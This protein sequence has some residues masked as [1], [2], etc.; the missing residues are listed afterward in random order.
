MGGSV[1][2][3]V[4]IAGVSR[5]SKLSLSVTWEVS[6]DPFQTDNISTFEVEKR[7]RHWAGMDARYKFNPHHSLALFAG[8]R[9]GGPACT[10]G[11][12]Y[13]V[14]DFQGVELRWISKF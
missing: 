12:C 10:S 14:L 9:R 13:E 4:L 11:I 2:T 8:Q 7:A 3:G 6:T 1:H 5:G